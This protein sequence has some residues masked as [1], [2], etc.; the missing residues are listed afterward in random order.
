MLTVQSVSLAYEDKTVLRDLS[1]HLAEGEVLCLLGASGSG[2]TTLLRIIA[3][4]Q[5]QHKGKIFFEGRDITQ[6]PIHQRQFGLM[7]QDNALFPHL[8]VAD[9]IAFGLK[10]QRRPNHERQ[11]RTRDLLELVNLQGY[12]KRD[13]ASLSGGERQRVALARS[14]APSPRL[15]MLDEPLASLDANLRQ[16]ILLDLQVILRQLRLTTLYVT[17]DQSEA[18]TLADKVAILNQGYL[19]QI[20]TPHELY[21]QPKTRYVARF[22]GLHNIFH[23]SD[24]PSS[25]RPPELPATDWLLVHPTGIHVTDD[26]TTGI[27]AIVR[28]KTYQG[29]TYHITVQTSDD[30]ELRLMTPAQIPLHIGQKL[31]ISI[32]PTAIIPLHDDAP[33]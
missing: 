2:K 8:N 9:N 24:L 5:T 13:V 12:E 11:S 32:A 27:P 23:V 25:W 17:H 28:H 30:I 31:L 20:A 10:M 7:F 26:E 14:L 33:E 4:L 18:F 1:L 22:L 15:L 19:E 16:Q 3:G 29:A 21:H 6:T